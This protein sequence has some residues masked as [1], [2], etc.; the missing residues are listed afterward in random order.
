MNFMLAK[1]KSVKYLIQ[2]H[3]LRGEM[4]RAR[5]NFSCGDEDD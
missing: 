2:R 3:T 5:Y 1:R 4:A